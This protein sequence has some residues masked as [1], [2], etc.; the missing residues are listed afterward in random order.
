MSSP[1]LSLLRILADNRFADIA[2]SRRKRKLIGR[3]SPCLRR[4]NDAAF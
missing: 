3:F 2:F 1:R 4:D